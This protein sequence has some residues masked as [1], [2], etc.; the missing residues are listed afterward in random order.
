VRARLKKL[1]REYQK[2]TRDKDEE[3]CFPDAMPHLASPKV[4][5]RH[6]SI[7]P[8][9]P[10]LPSA[11]ALQQFVTHDGVASRWPRQEVQAFRNRSSI[12][13]PELSELSSSREKEGGDKI[14][15]RE[16]QISS[17]MRTGSVLALSRQRALEMSVYYPAV[18]ASCIK[19]RYMEDPRAREIKK[20]QKKKRKKKLNLVK[21]RSLRGP[22]VRSDA[23]FRFRA[24]CAARRTKY[25]DA[26]PVRI[27]LANTG[28]NLSVRYM[29][30]IS[31][32]RPPPRAVEKSPHVL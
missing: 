4:S 29:I 16:Y 20:K 26:S 13:T 14:Y 30:V 31:Y 1:I 3:D 28:R 7:V 22:R 11:R 10:P 8:L 6:K 2:L 15:G 18:S 12:S 9:Y 19:R 24:V 21:A 17:T 23:S 32:P 25:G 27:H 5:L